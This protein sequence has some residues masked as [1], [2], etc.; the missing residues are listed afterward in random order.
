MKKT[1]FALLLL[2][3]LMLSAQGGEV[4]FSQ[5]G[6]VYSNPFTVSLQCTNSQY[7]IHYTLN[8]ATPTAASPTYSQPFSLGPHLYSTSNFYTIP[9]APENHIYMPESVL[10]AIVIR[11]A[12]FDANGNRVSPVVTQSYFIKSLNCD[13]H[14]L[15]VISLCADSAA[16]F[17]QDTGILVPG[18]HFDPEN[19]DWTGNYYENGRAWERLCNVEYYGAGNGGFN[20]QAGLRTHGGNGRR[21]QQKGLKIYAREEYG[22]KRFVHKIFDDCDVVRFKHLALK[23]F[24][25]AWNESGLTDCLSGRIGRNLDLDV[26][27]ARPAVL[28]ING[29]YWGIYYIQERSDERY[30]ENHYNINPDACVIVGNWWG[31]PEAGDPANFNTLMDWVENADLSDS[32][33]YS[34]I[35][36]Q[37]DIHNFIDYQIYEIFSANTDWPVNNMRCWQIDGRKWRWIFYDGDGCFLF[38]AF[39]GFAHA[40]SESTQ[41]WP[42]NAHSTLMFRKLLQNKQFQQ[43]FVTRYNELSNRHLAYNYTGRYLREIQ[44]EIEN[45]VSQQSQR[46]GTPKSMQ[47]WRSDCKAVD[48]FL[49]QRPDNMH[50]DILDFFHLKEEPLPV[51]FAVF[52]NPA[53]KQITIQFPADHFGLMEVRIANMSG[54]CCFSH[55]YAFQE[56]N[57]SIQIDVQNL[58]AGT[59]ILM[60]EGKRIKIVIEN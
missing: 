55:I 9:T 34:Y 36:S 47:S 20:Q 56:G 46:F 43:Q 41:E 11:A 1:L 24:V 54:Q 49:K 14:Q 18:V 23:P 28:F 48:R 38:P 52:P 31:L 27:A 25:S 29:E 7:L 50:K 51:A 33:A 16:L 2:F 15:P 44:S 21:H 13:L 42:T 59:Y 57:N 40:T 58:R 26:L 12:A 32:T 19:P 53:S 17:D 6:G 30:L 35:E 37:I 10:R 39:D 45:E 22:K 5:K 8:G 3:P 4:V 60:T